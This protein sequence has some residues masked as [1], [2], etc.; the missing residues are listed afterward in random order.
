MKDHA[1]IRFATD[2]MGFVRWA[3]NV[4]YHHPNFGWLVDGPDDW[5]N[6]YVDALQTRY[7]KKAIGRGQ[8]CIYLTFQ[9]CS[10]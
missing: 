8:K 4:F 7:E 3:L 9:R 10:R 2:D 1:K 5:H 6:R